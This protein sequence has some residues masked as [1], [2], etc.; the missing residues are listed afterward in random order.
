VGAR[1]LL[2]FQGTYERDA[3]GEPTDEALLGA[4]MTSE[5]QAAQIDLRDGYYQVHKK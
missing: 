3:D 1:A 2:A 5:V 4:I